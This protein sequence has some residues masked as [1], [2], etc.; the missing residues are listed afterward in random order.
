MRRVAELDAVRGVAG[1]VIVLYHFRE[2]LGLDAWSSFDRWGFL[3]VDLFFVLS[4]YLIT[5]IILKNYDK[6]DFIKNFYIRR[7]LRIWPIYYLVLLL[8]VAIN[9][10]L[11]QPYRL[12][13]L[14]SYLTYTQGVG[15]YWGAQ[16][17]PCT[18]P[19]GHTWTLA[20]EEQFYVLWPPL[21]MLCGRRR[22]V[23][24]CLGVAAFAAW[25]RW[26]RFGG[27]AAIYLLA[28]RCDG[29]AMGGLLA[30]MAAHPAWMERHRRRLR[31]AFVLT[32]AAMVAY[33]D[34][35]TRL[36]GRV[37]L[38]FTCVNLMLFSLMGLVLLHAGRPSLRALRDPRLCYVGLI[39]YGLYLYHPLV[40]EAASR[41][42]ALLGTGH[43]WWTT[44]LLLVGVF[45][46]AALSYH[47]IERPILALKDRFDYRSEP[48]P[49]PEPAPAAVA[50]IVGSPTG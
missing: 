30:A 35:A 26:M 32:A 27:A 47:L 14:L 25:S 29:F 42:E 10:L 21:L 50:R 40:E 44:A 41:V 7:S 15:R 45:A 33:C 13:D 37:P 36:L 48:G 38:T 2:R 17:R 5:S 28:G 22:V 4:G 9:P 49:T 8:F 31:V 43:R 24:V 6:K 23:P 1:T 16:A 19:L 12:D 34:L 3:A 20:I 18:A 46:V 39:S 11:S